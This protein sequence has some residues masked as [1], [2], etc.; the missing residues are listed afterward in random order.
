MKAISLCSGADGFGL[1]AQLLGIEV[2][3]HVEKEKSFDEHYKRHWPNAE[4]FYDITTVDPEAIADAD[5]IFGGEP[6]GPHSKAG[7][8]KGKEDNN[9]LWPSYFTICKAKRPTWIINEN[10]I[11]SVENLVLDTK[12]AD[13]ES[14]GYTCRTFNIPAC[15]VGAYHERKRIWLLAYTRSGRV[16]SYKKSNITQ[17]MHKEVYAKAGWFRNDFQSTTAR[18]VSGRIFPAPVGGLLPVVNDVSIELALHKAYGNA[19]V[20]W[21]PYVILKFILEIEK[22]NL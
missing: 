3:A 15:A 21:I 6:C 14:I 19:V 12:I 5:I 2:V 4:R 20:P 16:R 8:R 9:Y 22:S 10:V 1:A 11:G 18:G 17:R 7:R 13:L